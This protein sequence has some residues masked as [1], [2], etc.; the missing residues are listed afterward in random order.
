MHCLG[1]RHG[2]GPARGSV[3]LRGAHRGC[4][5]QP[6]Q[7]V[8]QQQAGDVRTTLARL[9]THTKLALPVAAAGEVT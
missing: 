8:G 3:N 6:G 4:Q 1:S 2:H 9:L 7:P 5:H